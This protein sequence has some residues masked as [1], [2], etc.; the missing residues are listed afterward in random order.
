MQSE[1]KLTLPFSQIRVGDLP[2]VGGKG[3]NLG[4]MTHAQLP[5]PPGFCVTTAAFDQFMAACPEAENLYAQLDA[6]DSA[7][8]EQ[9]R[10]IGKLV[11]ASLQSVAMPA[12]VSAAIES[13]WAQIGRNHAYAVRSSATAEDLPS[14]SFAGQQDTYLNLTGLDAVL[15]GVKRCWISLFTDRAILYRA[16]NEF[17]HRKVLLS[18]VVQQMIMAEKSGIMFTADPL[19]GHRHTTMINASYGLGEA[20]VGGLV[21]PD[22][23][24]VDKRDGSII[25]RKISDKLIAILPKADG[26]IE[27][28]ALHGDQRTQTTLDD[29]QIVA[30]AQLGSKVEAY[31][32]APQ[33]IEWAYFEHT[34]YLLQS[35]PITSLY[36]IENLQSDDGDLHIFYSMGNQQ[37]MTDAMPSLAISTLRSVLPIGHEK[38]EVESRFTRESGGRIFID[39]TTLLQTPVLRKLLMRLAGQFDALAPQIIATGMARP[40]FRRDKQLSIPWS[41]LRMGRAIAG[42]VVD[43]LWR[44]DVSDM[45][46]VADRL[47]AENVRAVAALL[48]QMPS[49]E[50]RVR[51]LFAIFPKLILVALNWIPVFIAAEIA[52]KLIDLLTKGYA[53]PADLEAYK[54]GLRGNVV[55][56]MNLALG[57]LADLARELPELAR[58]LADLG[59]DGQRWLAQA[60]AIDGSQP[61]FAAWDRFIALYGA[62][63]SAEIN[64]CAPRWYEDP[65][66]LLHTIAT[67]LQKEPG[68]ALARQQALASAR[69]RAVD[70]LLR[71]TKFGRFGRLRQRILQ[72]LLFVSDNGSVL[73]EHHKF[74]IIQHFRTIKELVKAV[75]QQFVGEQK[76]VQRDDIW[77]LRWPEILRLSADDDFDVAPLIKQRREALTHYQ[78]LT[79]PPILT[80]DGET[81]VANYQVADVA[82]GALLGNPVSPGVVEGVVH[83]IAD[84][85]RETIQPGEIL[86]AKYT[87]P[88]WTPLFINAAGLITEIGG[89]MTHGSVVARE[90]SLPAVVGV[91]DAT[92]ILHNGQRVRIDGNR[93]VIDL[94]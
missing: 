66:P 20:L 89:A 18:A 26:G 32:A 78:N 48:E 29:A 53:D 3:A 54:L 60:R 31:Y 88:G 74:V 41:A 87:D 30:L 91:R 67:D 80:S 4:E 83:I 76:L 51:A 58:L 40:E 21:S 6:V 64:I 86:V 75:G 79:P 94:L 52:Q 5:I 25:G 28:V 42:Q 10:T 43:A 46:A 93:G 39:I 92:T 24:R 77:F 44:R 72:R 27:Q 34:F 19:T 69:E 16:R 23:Y 36:P 81:P 59:D 47:S 82:E 71:Q 90:Y 63:G 33:D 12:E 85:Q 38:G 1:H 35:R 68:R 56:E 14:A 45:A 50:M 65:L 62:R 13:E 2:L 22:E 70:N 61:F 17:D 84:P 57:E 9:A 7:D 37:M 73:R 11:R 15:D 8:V 55:I 49:A